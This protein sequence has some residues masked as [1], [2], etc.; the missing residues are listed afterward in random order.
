M[1]THNTLG[2]FAI[3]ATE[4][5]ESVITQCNDKQRGQINSALSAGAS[6]SVSLTLDAFG[7]SVIQVELLRGKKRFV[8]ASVMGDEMQ[9]H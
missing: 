9:I 8:L 1:M 5:F 2:N 6:A 4:V 7:N 3:T